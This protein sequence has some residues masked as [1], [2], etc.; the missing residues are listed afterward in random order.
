MI[1]PNA[2]S[3]D[4]SWRFCHCRD[5]DTDN[6]YLAYFCTIVLVLP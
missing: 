4:N 1:E 3:T 5:V 2:A 6:L